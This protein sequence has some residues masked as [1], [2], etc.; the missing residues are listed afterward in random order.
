MLA[1]S[2]ETESPLHQVLPQEVREID[3]VEIRPG[4]LQV[5]VE[6]RRVGL[7]VREFEI[8]CVLA[9][10]YDRVVPRPEVYELVWGGRMPRRDRSVDVFV[11]KVRFK[12]TAVAPDWIFIHTHFGIGYRFKPERIDGLGPDS[13]S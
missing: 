10:R 11:R 3:N 2:P 4:E 1:R 9:E 5:F 13:P 7:T 8:F 12:L 6:G